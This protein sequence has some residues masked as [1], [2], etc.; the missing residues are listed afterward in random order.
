MILISSVMLSRRADKIHNTRK[1]QKYFQSI[2]KF[3][4]RKNSC[5]EVYN[6]DINE[7]KCDYRVFLEMIFYISMANYEMH[8][9]EWRIFMR[10]FLWVLCSLPSPSKYICQQEVT[11]NLCGNSC[12]VHLYHECI[13]TAVQILILLKSKEVLLMLLIINFCPRKQSRGD[14]NAFI[15]SKSS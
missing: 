6:R 2:K 8:I 14:F 13:Q 5:R 4:W 15:R 7:H 3:Q 12:W 1:E 10:D 11:N 9:W